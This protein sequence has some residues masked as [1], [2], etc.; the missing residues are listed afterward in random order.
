MIDRGLQLMSRNPVE[1]S[2]ALAVVMALVLM[3]SSGCGA[4]SAGEVSGRVFLDDRP[5][6]GAVIQLKPKGN[7]EAKEVSTEVNNG[8]FK[9]SGAQWIK[10]GEYYVMFTSQQP[11]AGAIIDGVQTGKGIPA[12]KAFVP[13]AYEKKGTLSATISAE[14]PSK[15]LF[16]LKSGGF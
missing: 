4:Q 16:Q 9:F 6:D 15:L 8:E 12:P 13:K 1:A 5:L 10:P 2:V 11:G 7:P 3:I 14:G